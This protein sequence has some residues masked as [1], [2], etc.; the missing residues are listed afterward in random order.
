[1][2]KSNRNYA[3][4]QHAC[5]KIAIYKRRLQAKKKKKPLNETF[6][7]EHILAQQK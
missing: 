4:F 5:H 6:G 3:Y 2:Y 7:A 1:M